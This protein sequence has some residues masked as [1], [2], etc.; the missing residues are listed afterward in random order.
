MVVP[1]AAARPV[2]ESAPAAMARYFAKRAAMPELATIND[3]FKDHNIRIF[4]SF[5]GLGLIE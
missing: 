1:S 2:A 5:S 4:L 3:L